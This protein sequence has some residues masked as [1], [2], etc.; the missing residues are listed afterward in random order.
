MERIAFNTMQE[1]QQI[2]EEQAASGKMVI[3]V[4]HDDQ[5]GNYVELEDW[6]R[7]KY[8]NETVRP[9]RT[10]LLTETDHFFYVDNYNRL[11]E[12]QRLELEEYRQ[13]LRD[14]TDH[15]PQNGK[16]TWPE[17]PKIDT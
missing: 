4:V 5:K 7:D 14:I 17:K 10:L 2:V 8:I 3:R 12:Q 16:V 15:V 13:K 1:R 6:D 11:T 9:K